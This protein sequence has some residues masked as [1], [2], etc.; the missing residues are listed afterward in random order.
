MPLN[1]CISAKATTVMQ[2][3]GGI[4]LVAEMPRSRKNIF[5][6][7]QAGRSVIALLNNGVARAGQ[8]LG[9]PAIPGFVSSHVAHLL[10]TA[11]L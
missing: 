2:S 11:L 4:E 9:L 3:Q 1:A 8:G 5:V 7:Q 10:L 6:D